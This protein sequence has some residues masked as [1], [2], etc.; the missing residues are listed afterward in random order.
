MLNIPL[1]R[2]VQESIAD[3]SNPFDMMNWGTCVCAH[4]STI[5]DGTAI[6]FCYGQYE[7]NPRETIRILGLEGEEGWLV[8]GGYNRKQ[9]IAKID[10]LIEAEEATRRTALVRFQGPWLVTALKAVPKPQQQAEER[11]LACV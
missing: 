7:Y 11:E 8:T 6:R 5:L 10:A 4:A 2:K 3:P 9:A 1:L